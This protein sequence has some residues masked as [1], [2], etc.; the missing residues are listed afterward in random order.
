MKTF[1]AIVCLLLMISLSGCS[2]GTTVS[3]EDDLSNNTQITYSI[4]EISGVDD[5]TY[6]IGEPHPDYFSGVFISDDIYDDLESS[7]II[8]D[9]S[10]NYQLEGQYPVIYQVTNPDGRYDHKIVTVTVV[11]PLDLSLLPEDFMIITINDKAGIVSMDGTLILET[12]Y[13][14]IKFLNDALLY[15]R[16]FDNE[17]VYDVT[18]QTFI[19]YDYTPEVIGNTL[20]IYKEEAHFGLMDSEGTKL[21]EP[22]YDDA[23]LTTHGYV[24]VGIYDE[25]TSQLLYGVIDNDLNVIVPIIYEELSFKTNGYVFTHNG[26]SMYYSNNVKQTYPLESL[27]TTS[28]DFGRRTLYAFPTETGD[29]L[30]DETLDINIFDDNSPYYLTD[31]KW[32]NNQLYYH[33]H[34]PTHTAIYQL[35]TQ[36]K[37]MTPTIK[38]LDDLNQIADSPYF[39]YQDNTQLTLY[40]ADFNLI[41]SIQ[42]LTKDPDVQKVS[43]WLYL[44]NSPTEQEY[45]FIDLNTNQLRQ[46]AA[47]FISYNGD[48]V[49]FY[50]TQSSG[51]HRTYVYRNQIIQL[52]NIYSMEIQ[53]IDDSYYFCASY[54]DLSDLFTLSDNYGGRL[55]EE[56]IHLCDLFENYFLIKHTDN[57]Y[58]IIDETRRELL[59]HEEFIYVLNEDY[60]SPKETDQTGNVYRIFNIHSEAFLSETYYFDDVAPTD[61]DTAY[62]NYYKYP[63]HGHGLLGVTQQGIYPQTDFYDASGTLIASIQSD[64][65]RIINENYILYRQ[66]PFTVYGIYDINADATIYGKMTHY[67]L[68]IYDEFIILFN[69]SSGRGYVLNESDFSVLY[70]T[71]LDFH[72]SGTI[73]RVSVRLGLIEIHTVEDGY[74]YHDFKYDQTYH[75]IDRVYQNNDY[76]IVT[77]ISNPTVNIF[78]KNPDGT[79]ETLRSTTTAERIS[80]EGPLIKYNN[81]VYD[82]TMTYLFP[83]QETYLESRARGTDFIVLK[84]RYNG[85][86]INRL[87]TFDPVTGEIK[88][89]EEMEHSY[90]YKLVDNPQYMA[91]Y[92]NR[93]YPG[94]IYKK[95]P[96]NIYLEFFSADSIHQLTDMFMIIS[97]DVMPYSYKINRYSLEDNTVTPII[98]IKKANYN[99]ETST[100]T[101]GN[102]QL[103][104]NN[105]TISYD[106]VDYDDVIGSFDND[107]IIL[108]KNPTV[109]TRYTTYTI[110]YKYDGALTNLT[111]VPEKVDITLY[112]STLKDKQLNETTILFNQ[113]GILV[114]YAADT[115]RPHPELD[116]YIIEN[117]GAKGLIDDSGELIIPAEYQSITLHDNYLIA[118]TGSLYHVYD[119]N[120]NQLLTSPVND[121]TIH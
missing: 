116:M 19:S 46:H 4:P 47:G 73:D 9:A 113:E 70:D 14:E 3:E 111:S 107:Y 81:A 11:M 12:I 84:T 5:L 74:Y 98:T 121:I 62:D 55:L 91:L 39:I 75:T 6:Y 18:E 112:Q 67:N 60:V 93:Y 45:L 53:E 72:A 78:R 23:F 50:Y 31:K 99:L 59:S 106:G 49:K 21:T 114:S 65:Y 15:I 16:L 100:I 52:D 51:S 27:E 89:V 80:L 118:Q 69:E 58:S 120:G 63:Y 82:I 109:E 20:S 85:E 54:S 13:D 7:L 86:D 64:Y 119:L 77:S 25:D 17:R 76:Y 104:L 117:F 36:T 24:Q 22:I 1:Y 28:I 48:L 10:V 44:F 103:T 92:Y 101:Y 79:L 33:L 108:Q 115:I 43:E 42:F 34:T 38:D 40:D 97:D 66:L 56:D 61:Y 68:A 37:I 71:N 94:V 87:I 57:T 41:D 29:L 102:H 32:M 30:L 96:S 90:P 26:S 110:V 105:T 35:N 2:N 95:A 8:D 88:H 83:N